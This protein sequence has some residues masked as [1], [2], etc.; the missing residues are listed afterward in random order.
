MDKIFEPYFTT[1]EVGKG[2]GIGLALVHGIVKNY[3]GAVSVQSEVGN[4]TIF[5]VYLPLIEGEMD[6]LETGKDSVQLPTGKE[7][8]LVVD[9]EK[10]A[11]DA[12][13][14]MLER[15][16]YKVTARTSS[17]EA[18]EAFRNR[19]DGFDLVITDQTMPNMTGKELAKELM[20]LRPDIPII[21]CTG[22]SEQ[23]D[24]RR[25]K[26]MGISAFVMKPIVM[27]QIAQ[28]IREVLDKK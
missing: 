25:A 21:L 10:G 2:T 27:R 1:K 17:I 20:S 12:I 22:F 16:G 5:H 23:I 6:V 15:L 28:T 14:L 24:E 18:L 11:V 8:I 4:G 9:D 7:R 3:G 26:E 19:P 13:Q